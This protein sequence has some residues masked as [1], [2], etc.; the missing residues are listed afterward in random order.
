MSRQ[1]K[2]VET[3]KGTDMGKGGDHYLYFAVSIF[4]S[5]FSGA[6]LLVS[7]GALVF[8]LKAGVNV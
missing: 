5:V 8:V 6:L 3:I 1:F 7:S 2:E 4:L